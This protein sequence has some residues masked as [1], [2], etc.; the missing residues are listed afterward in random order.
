MLVAILVAALVAFAPVADAFCPIDLPLANPP[1]SAASTGELDHA[2]DGHDTDPCCEHAASLMA[3]SDSKIDDAAAATAFSFDRPLVL[4][5]SV[6]QPAFSQAP[7][8]RARA[9]PPRDPAPLFRRLKR[10]L[11]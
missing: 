7:W 3:A 4:A 9:G 5:A 10:L 2:A 6:F 8:R 1:S 11:I